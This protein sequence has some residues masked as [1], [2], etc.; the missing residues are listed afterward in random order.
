MAVISA[1]GEERAAMIAA[2][3]DE[4]IATLKEV[5]A[6]GKRAADSTVAALR[7]LIDYTL[8]R[9]A[10][11]CLGLLLVAGVFGLI[12]LRLRSGWRRHA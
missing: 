9:V 6:I 4:R 2:L 11:L 3:R 10:V 5:D 1:L 12:A 8:W 7:D